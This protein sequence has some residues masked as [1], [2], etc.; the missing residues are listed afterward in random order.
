MEAGGNGRTHVFAAMQTFALASFASLS[1]IAS[2]MPLD[3][4]LLCP[5]KASR[6]GRSQ[7]CG[8]G[9]GTGGTSWRTRRQ[10]GCVR[11]ASLSSQSEP[12][13]EC[14]RCGRS[15]LLLGSTS[16]AH[17]LARL[18]APRCPH[19]N[20]LT[21]RFVGLAGTCT[22]L[23]DELR[24]QTSRRRNSVDAERRARAHSS[25]RAPGSSRRRCLVCRC[26]LGGIASR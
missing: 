21:T 15:Q 22:S 19:L 16:P 8:D 12:V 7:R 2:P 26:G 10:S 3:P 5:A 14:E 24:D 1:A 9:A 23:T 4:P 25:P 17:R 6:S 13:S 18:I 20:S 11:W